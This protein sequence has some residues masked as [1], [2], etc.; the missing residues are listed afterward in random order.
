MNGYGDIHIIN[1]NCT[2]HS[3]YNKLLIACD[4]IL[5]GD[6]ENRII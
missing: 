3:V 5:L 6:C 4:S 1:I 2:I